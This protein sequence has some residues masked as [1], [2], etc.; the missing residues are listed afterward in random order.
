MILESQSK[1]RCF[2]PHLALSQG[3]LIADQDQI[4]VSVGVKGYSEGCVIKEGLWLHVD[5]PLCPLRRCVFHDLPDHAHFVPSALLQSRQLR[6]VPALHMGSSDSTVS[7]S[8]AQVYVK[9]VLDGMA[10]G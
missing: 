4:P 8:R 5:D 7:T 9:L 3:C 2:T 6:L 10:G 1:R